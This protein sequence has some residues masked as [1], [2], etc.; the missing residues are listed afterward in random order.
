MIQKKR[1]NRNKDYLNTIISVI[2]E[3]PGI[4]QYFNDSGEIIYVGK[5]K[6]LK[7]RVSSYFS[8]KH[9]QRKTALL[10]YHI[11]DIT[12]MVVD[13]EEDALLLENNLIKKYKPRYNIRLKDDKTYP[14][15]CIKNERYPRVFKTRKVIR[16]GSR[17]YGPYT[18]YLTVN[19]LLDLF[20]SLY[21]LRTCNYHLSEENTRDG[22][23]KLCLEYH[24][25][26]CFGPCQNLISEEKYNENIEEIAHI[27]K[28][29][30]TG[31]IR[32]MKQLMEGYATRYQFEEAQQMKEKIAL[33]EKYQSRSAVVSP[34]ICNVDVFSIVADEKQAFVNYLKVLNGAIIQTHTVE[35]GKK[36]EEKKEDILLLAIVDV[37]QRLYS[38]AKEIIVPFNLSTK[39]KGITF[40]VPFRGDKKHLLDLSTRNAMYYRREAEKHKTKARSNKRTDRILEQL[41]KDLQLK[42]LPRHIEC[43]DNSNLQGSDPV[44]SCVV[45]KNAVPAKKE[46]RH[47]AIKTVKGPDD[48]AS[49]QEVVYRR[50]KRLL[51]EE[52]SLPQLMVIDGGKGQLSSAVKALEKLNLRGKIAIIGIAKKLEELYFPG[53]EIPLYLDKTS[54]SLKVIQHLRNEA[55]RFGINYHRNKRSKNML[56]SELNAIPGIG[57]KTIQKLITTYRSVK[58]IRELSYGELTA[59]IG[60]AKASLIVNYFTENQPD[61]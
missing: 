5:A 55:H 59:E 53:D 25:G 42:Q 3:K 27:L 50:Y 46:Y 7:R 44:A 34:A 58:K 28:G 18:S 43:F 16:D 12:Y 60:N 9:K 45:F 2:P 39:L 57:P 54:E 40:H 22:K 8:Q 35:I 10:V 13:T 4:Y 11:A 6:N 14:W 29:N 32:Q 52:K 41:K 15:I 17:Y 30:I 51:E 33:L 38:D 36:L 26:N 24:I 37:R 48:F 31:V 49:M 19:T 56:V 21:K 47:F 23:Y 61:G 20:R 1:T